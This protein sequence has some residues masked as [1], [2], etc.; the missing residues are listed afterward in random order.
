MWSVYPRM[1]P[2][3][4]WQRRKSSWLKNPSFLQQKHQDRMKKRTC[5]FWSCSRPKLGLVVVAPRSLYWLLPVPSFSVW[6]ANLPKA[7]FFSSLLQ[8]CKA[9]IW[10]GSIQGWQISNFQE[11]LQTRKAKM[12]EQQMNPIPRGMFYEHHTSW[13]CCCRPARERKPKTILVIGHKITV[14]QA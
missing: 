12:A 4:L 11:I 3:F 7:C 2:P 9:T 13:S 6:D 14:C 5:G 1:I 8:N 10:K